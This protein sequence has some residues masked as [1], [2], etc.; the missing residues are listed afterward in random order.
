MKSVHIGSFF[1][2]GF[3]CIRSEYGGLLRIESNLRI[4]SEYKK[5]LPIWT[6]FKQ[7]F[8]A[9]YVNLIVKKSRDGSRLLQHP[10]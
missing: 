7:W 3:C 5:I 9:K 6:L 1:W 2:P 10:R 8:V 4:Q